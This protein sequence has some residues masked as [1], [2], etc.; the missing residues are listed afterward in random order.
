MM[1]I[2]IIYNDDGILSMTWFLNGRLC[3]ESAV[4]V[5]RMDSFLSSAQVRFHNRCF[6]VYAQTGSQRANL[7]A[8]KKPHAPCRSG[9]ISSPR[10][11]SLIDSPY[12]T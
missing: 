2:I 1:I 3:F 7:I 12:F 10:V 8:S 11:L 6:I 5:V 4:I 9:Q